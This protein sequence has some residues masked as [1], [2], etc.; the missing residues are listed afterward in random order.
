MTVPAVTFVAFFPE[1][2]CMSRMD[3]EDCFLTLLWFFGYTWTS[4]VNVGDASG[5][6]CAKG[7]VT[8]DGDVEEASL[9]PSG[10]AVSTRR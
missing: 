2:S 6:A 5:F 7:S 4:L 8:I 3:L 10:A 1:A 9:Y